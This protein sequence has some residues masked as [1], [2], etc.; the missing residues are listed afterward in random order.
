MSTEHVLTVNVLDVN[1]NKPVL[2]T[3]QAS[4]CVKNLN[5]VI[6]K[7]EDGDSE[8][9]SEPFS[10]TLDRQAKYPNWRLEAIDGTDGNVLWS[11]SRVG[12]MDEWMDG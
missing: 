12:W 10:F 5:P 4:V 1:D 8:P 7:A 9:F 3:K 11:S 2:T 6:V